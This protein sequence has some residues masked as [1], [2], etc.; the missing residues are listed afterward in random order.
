M[1]VRVIA[2]SGVSRSPE[3][4]EGDVAISAKKLK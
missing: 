3:R 2:R 4:S 1:P